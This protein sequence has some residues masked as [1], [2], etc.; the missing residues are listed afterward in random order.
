M[1]AA[2]LESMFAL[3]SRLALQ[4]LEFSVDFTRLLGTGVSS[5]VYGGKLRRAGDS[6]DV[7]C[8]VIYAPADG[9]ASVADTFRAAMHEAVQ[10]DRFSRILY[11]VWANSSGTE[12]TSGSELAILV[13]RR[14]IPI[15]GLLDTARENESSAVPPR[16][17]ACLVATPKPDAWREGDRLPDFAVARLHLASRIADCVYSLHDCRTPHGDIKPDNVLVLPDGSVALIDFGPSHGT[18]GFVPTELRSVESTSQSM[19][20][21][22]YALGM[23][24]FDVLT[25]RRLS[26]ARA[27][28][29]AAAA[30]Q[31]AVLWDTTARDWWIPLRVRMALEHACSARLST[32]GLRAVLVDAISGRKALADGY[33]IGDIGPQRM[34]PLPEHISRRVASR[35]YVRSDADDTLHR[36]FWPGALPLAPSASAGVAQTAETSSG[37]ERNPTMLLDSR[38]MARATY[39]GA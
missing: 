28:L 39:H 18:P 17:A 9:R 24:V 6:L 31:D 3:P 25:V 34:H 10:L 29:A 38:S 30:R 32:A 36:W 12:T 21:D 20:T 37:P 35:W 15:R 19:A 4:K 8:K 16:E 23:T 1:D 33:D 27:A 26:A 13:M 7:A 2:T 22:D 5:K 14:G 11:G